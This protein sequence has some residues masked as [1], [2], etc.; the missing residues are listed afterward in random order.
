MAYFGHSRVVLYIA[1]SILVLFVA[2]FESQ[3]R[4][5]STI[6]TIILYIQPKKVV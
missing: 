1:H 2:R 6:Y 4:T 3:F 5:E